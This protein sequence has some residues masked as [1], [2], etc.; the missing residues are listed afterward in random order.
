MPS[1]HKFQW[2]RHCR[3]ITT[4]ER[5]VLRFLVDE[6]NGDGLVERLNARTIAYGN[7]ISR[8]Y[9]F[10]LLRDLQD[11]GFIKE[12]LARNGPNGV[13]ISNAYQLDLELQHPPDTK[14][15]QGA[16]LGKLMARLAADDARVPEHYMEDAAAW[17]DQHHLVLVFWLPSRAAGRYFLEHQQALAAGIRS[18]ENLIKVPLPEA[19]EFLSPNGTSSTARPRQRNA[20]PEDSEENQSP[21]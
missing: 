14:S 20:S 16:R 10:E 9:V 4:G 18:G 8:R 12:R 15:Q 6:A 1:P 21:P 7:G 2:I 13:R 17:Y 19:F 3:G 5:C 11:K